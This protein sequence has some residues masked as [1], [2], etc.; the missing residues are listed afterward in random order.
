MF[1]RIRQLFSRSTDRN[2]V[3]S[4]RYVSRRER[5]NF[6]RRLVIIGIIAAAVILVA[7]LATGAV[8]QYIYLPNET[9]ASVDGVKIN[10]ADYWK[11][12]KY[13]LIT[14]IQ[15]YSQIASLMSGDQATQ[16]QQLAQQAQTELGTVKT[17]PVNSSTVQTMVNNVLTVNNASKAGVT[18]TAA[19]V[20]Q[21][22]KDFYSPV[23][24]ASPT[25]TLGA[26][27][28]AEAWATATAKANPTPTT[29]PTPT[30]TPTKSATPK[31]SSNSATK[32]AGNATPKATG[33]PSASP[34]ASPTAAPTP[35]PNAA[36]AQATASATKRLF[37]SNV[38]NQAGMSESD[39]ERLV[40]KPEVAQEKVT[41]ALQQQVRTSGEQIHAAHI[42]VKTKDAANVIE[43]QLKDGQNFATLAKEKS[44][45]ATTAV[46]GG[47]L[48][49]FPQGVNTPAFDKVAFSLKVGQV[50]QPLQ[51]SYGWD[52]IKVL[53]KQEN[54]PIDLK[55]LQAL[56]GKVFQNWLDQIKSQSKVTWNVAQPTSTA[57][58]VTTFS[59]PPGAPPTP[60]PTPAPTPSPTPKGT[61][62][63]PTP[64]PKG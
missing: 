50:S 6:H 28:T 15:Q 22:M 52:I 30:P 14:Q 45:D 8:Y 10:K 47:D 1:D 56:R 24:S 13:E 38:L 62:P 49:W 18:V 32:A 51:T 44:A 42:V 59:P 46:N 33:S 39:F 27:P 5:E 34:A 60:T 9:L 61:K 25:P 3:G 64:T 26:N 4:T 41:Y 29:A 17:D 16:Y 54:R 48:G 7:I 57:T 37:K 23:P 36:Q 43:Q 58:P 2:R 53:G 12:R 19:D 63:K 35:T 20:N 31:A 21:Y 40:A 11:M 55:T